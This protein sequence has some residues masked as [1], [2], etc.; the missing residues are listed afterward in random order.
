MGS[1]VDVEYVGKILSGAYYANRVR[2]ECR[3]DQLHFGTGETVP[4]GD[5]ALLLSPIC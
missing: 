2:S 1:L 4:A 5:E 3:S